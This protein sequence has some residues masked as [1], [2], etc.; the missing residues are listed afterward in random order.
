MARPRVLVTG[1][2][3]SLDEWCEAARGAGWEALPFALIEIEE[4]AP[5]AD[6]ARALLAAPHPERLCVTSVHALP[7]LA[8]LAAR[9]PRL[10]A[11][12]CSVVGQKSVGRLRALGFSGPIDWHASAEALRSELFALEPRPARVLWPRGDKSDELAR[13]LREAGV[14]VR[15]PLAYR[16][17]PRTGGTPPQGELVFFASP[18]AVRAWSELGAECPARALAIGATTFQALLGEKRLAF[19]DIISLSEPTSSAFAAALQH[20]DLRSTP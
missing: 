19:S 6:E 10:A 18:S 17:R 8:A 3:E 12:P 13:V 5:G 2:V 7:F 11:L 9:E 14:E 20:I 1:P 16:N 15:D 4:L